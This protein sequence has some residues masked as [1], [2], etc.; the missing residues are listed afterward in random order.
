MNHRWKDNVCTRCGIARV[1][2][3]WKLLM[4]I[5]PDGKNHYKYGTAWWYG[6]PNSNVKCL[7]KSIGFERPECK[8][9]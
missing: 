1:R 3:S 9:A 7:I 2:R 4:A 6:T 8:K 5:T